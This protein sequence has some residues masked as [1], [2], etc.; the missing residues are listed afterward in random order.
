MYKRIL[1]PLDGSKVA[2][3]VL[4][5]VCELASALRAEVVLLRVAPTADSLLGNG[6]VVGNRATT[7][8]GQMQ[9][10]ALGYLDRVK[11]GLGAV[12]AGVSCVAVSGPVAETIAEWAAANQVDLIALTSHGLG[13]AAR[14]VF[15]SVADRLLQA[16]KAP[17]L[18]VRASTELLQAQEEQEEA[19]MDAALL[20]ALAPGAQT[21]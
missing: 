12:G 13:H 2:E 5:Q 15:G 14:W 4:P 6:V 11:A 19:E 3:G 10:S 16:S 7:L 9:R 21:T 20:Q 17:V 18:V 1:V 8:E